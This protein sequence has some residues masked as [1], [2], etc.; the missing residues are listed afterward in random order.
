MRPACQVADANKDKV[1]DS[2]N[3]Q[4]PTP[5]EIEKR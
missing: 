4:K 2:K 3:K 1:I 5:P